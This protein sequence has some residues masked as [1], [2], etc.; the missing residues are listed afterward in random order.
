MPGIVEECKR[1]VFSY[2]SHGCWSGQ[3]PLEVTGQLTGSTG[4]KADLARHATALRVL[5]DYVQWSILQQWYLR[6][7]CSAELYAGSSSTSGS[8][9][10]TQATTSARSRLD[11]ATL[12]L[13]RQFSFRT[14]ELRANPP[15]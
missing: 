15:V 9:G 10:Q 11:H 6:D 2:K 13:F 14:L 5:K 4:G 12:Q 7:L 1:L 8:K 3:P